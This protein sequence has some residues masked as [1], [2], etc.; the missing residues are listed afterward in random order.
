[1]RVNKDDKITKTTIEAEQ[2]AASRSSKYLVYFQELQE[3]LEYMKKPDFS[4]YIKSVLELFP[5]NSNVRILFNHF[6]PPIYGKTMVRCLLY[7]AGKRTLQAGY[8]RQI[9]FADSSRRRTKSTP[10]ALLSTSGITPY[11]ILVIPPYSRDK[12][13]VDINAFVRNATTIEEIIAFFTFSSNV[14]SFAMSTHPSSAL[15]DNR[16]IDTRQIVKYRQ[17][18]NL[19]QKG[20]FVSFHSGS[21][22]W[23]HLRI[24]ATPAYYIDNWEEYLE[25]PLYRKV[26]KEINKYPSKDVTVNIFTANYDDDDDESNY[27]CNLNQM[28]RVPENTPLKSI[29]YDYFNI[30]LTEDE[31]QAQHLIKILDSTIIVFLASSFPNISKPRIMLPTWHR[32]FAKSLGSVLREE[33]KIKTVKELVVDT[34]A[35]VG[36]VIL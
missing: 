10:L 15:P 26:L 36:I 19:A 3:F 35:T 27:I 8:H 16:P 22:G 28:L 30:P 13:Y 11:P 1:M 6:I 31:E 24:D 12:D 25:N 23:L 7:D 5:P 20:V 4:L 29:L 34:T 21:V 9:Y 17:E 18:N 33:G 2:A 14:I 32:K